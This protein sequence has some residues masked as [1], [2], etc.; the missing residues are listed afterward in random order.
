MSTCRTCNGT[1]E[2]D[3][4]TTD[5]DGE[6]VTRHQPCHA[7]AGSGERHDWPPPGSR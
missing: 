5:D 3:I 6:R 2:I 1:G 4:I 7:C